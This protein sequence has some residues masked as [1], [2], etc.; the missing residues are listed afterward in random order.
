LY[1]LD[2]LTG[3]LV[4]FQGCLSTGA[5]PLDE[6][7]DEGDDTEGGHAS[8]AGDGGRVGIL[9]LDVIDSVRVVRL[10]LGD[11]V[12]G[13][14]GDGGVSDFYNGLDSLTDDLGG[15]VNVYWVDR[16]GVRFAI[17]FVSRLDSRHLLRGEVS[18]VQRVNLPVSVLGGVTRV[19]IGM[20][21][22]VLLSAHG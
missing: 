21:L 2:S 5:L 20:A 7:E 14:D 11:A 18:D 12:R 4:A 6:E 1:G 3:G 16:L 13:G 19:G 22:D 17:H 15:G 9:R 10:L 8:H